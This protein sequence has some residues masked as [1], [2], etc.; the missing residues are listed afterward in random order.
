LSCGWRPLDILHQTIEVSAGLAQPLSQVLQL[1]DSL[2][3]ISQELIDPLEEERALTVHEGP[4]GRR[5]PVLP[6]L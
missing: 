6:L 1:E 5:F 4:S 2:T 3:A